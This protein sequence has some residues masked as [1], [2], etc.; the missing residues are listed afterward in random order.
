MPAYRVNQIA[1]YGT[2][3]EH[4]RA[5]QT[6]LASAAG[7]LGRHYELVH[8]TEGF[9]PA[10]SCAVYHA[11]SWRVSFMQG[12]ARHGRIFNSESKAREYF[13]QVTSQ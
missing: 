2:Y 3:P 6:V 4:A 7:A 12:G 10:G 1:E 5:V 9:R 11:E 13:A 8:M